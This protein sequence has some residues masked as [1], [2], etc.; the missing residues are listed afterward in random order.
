M[1]ATI[2]TTTPARMGRCMLGDPWIRCT[3]RTTP[4]KTLSN[5]ACHQSFRVSLSHNAELNATSRNVGVDLESRGHH[6]PRTLGI[7]HPA[8]AVPYAG[9]EIDG[10]AGAQYQVLGTD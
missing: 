1:R 3:S 4:R 5:Y 10:I 8:V 2:F 9:I 6:D 7:A